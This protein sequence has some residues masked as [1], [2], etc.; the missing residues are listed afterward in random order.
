MARV[1][2]RV[3]LDEPDRVFVPGDHVRGRVEVEV[4]ED[5]SCRALT[6]APGWQTFGEANAATGDRDPVNL[7]AGEWRAGDRRSFPF[8]LMVPDGPPTYEG[9][10]FSVAWTVRAAASLSFAFDGKG[11]A[12][13][14]VSTVPAGEGTLLTKQ[15]SGCAEVGCAAVALA[16]LVGGGAPILLSRR[17]PGI[18]FAIAA[19]AGGILAAIMIPFALA[20]RRIG[21]VTVEVGPAPA[22]RGEEVAVR[23]VITPRKNLGTRRVRAELIATERA[24]K[25]SGKGAKWLTTELAKAA[26]TLDGPLDLVAGREAVYAGMLALPGDAP[27]TLVAGDHTVVWKLKVSVENPVLPDPGWTFDLPVR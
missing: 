3:V 6:A 2:L 7:A 11:E 17:F 10:T 22:A 20:Y 9:R 8:S 27:P 21:K 16:F 1:R 24:R 15:D 23:A 4:D 5:C 12:P 18:G 26:T 19:A 14:T 25:G 13:I